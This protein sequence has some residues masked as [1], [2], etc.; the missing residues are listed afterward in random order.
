MP[1]NLPNINTPLNFQ[2]EPNK[3]R[4]LPE[5]LKN[6]PYAHLSDEEILKLY[7]EMLT[8]PEKFNIPVMQP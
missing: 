3:K 2:E 6:N 5:H 7:N 1:D 8:N 4:E